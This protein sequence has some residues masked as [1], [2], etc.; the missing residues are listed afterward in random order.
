MI[1]VAGLVTPSATAQ[2]GSAKRIT[3]NVRNLEGR[4]IA[5]ADQADKLKTAIQVR[6]SNGD[7]A[8][9]VRTVRRLEDPIPVTNG[10]TVTL[11]VVRTMSQPYD[12]RLWTRIIS[13]SRG[14]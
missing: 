6:V 9:P 2:D 1:L 3:I 5:V 11:P 4:T 13:E 8:A 10:D 14:P 12:W 7:P